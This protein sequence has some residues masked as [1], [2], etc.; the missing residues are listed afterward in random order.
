MQ[1]GQ[2]LRLVLLEV[3]Y[4]VERRQKRFE[5]VDVFVTIGETGD[6]EVLGRI[7]NAKM[8]VND[9]VLYADTRAGLE[10][11]VAQGMHHS[12]DVGIE[13]RVTLFVAGRDYSR[14]FW[15]LYRVIS[16][17][18][19]RWRKHCPFDAIRCGASAR[20]NQGNT[21]GGPDFVRNFEQGR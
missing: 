1:I 13:L 6:L 16:N 2:V 4:P 3:E 8:Q 20:K 7:Q 5:H 9:R 11:E 15:A 12:S 14:G 17:V 18:T 10:S 19:C 21:T